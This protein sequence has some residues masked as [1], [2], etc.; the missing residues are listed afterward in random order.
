MAAAFCVVGESGAIHE[1]G[2]LYQRQEPKRTGSGEPADAKLR[3]AFNKTTPL[4]SNPH[5]SN[6]SCSS[7]RLVADTL[8]L[9][10]SMILRGPGSNGKR[11]RQT[12]RVRKKGGTLRRETQGRGDK[13][14]AQR[15]DDGC[16]MRTKEKKRGGH[17]ATTLPTNSFH[18]RSFSSCSFIRSSSSCL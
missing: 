12:E 2:S 16:A 1:N 10:S 3:T 6:S 13:I 5:L 7:R 18:L 8:S 15:N 17:H 4:D 9:S 11:L 14:A